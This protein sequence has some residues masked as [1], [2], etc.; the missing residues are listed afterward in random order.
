MVLRV[1]ETPSLSPPPLSAVPSVCRGSG[2]RDRR[3]F[4]I[5]L[6]SLGSPFPGRGRVGTS[7]FETRGL[8]ALEYSCTRRFEIS[9]VGAL[10]NCGSGVA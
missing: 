2:S 3:V 9:T 1:M 7:T 5:S 8:L 6:M 10:V 4:F